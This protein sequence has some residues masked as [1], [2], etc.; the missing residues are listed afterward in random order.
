MRLARALVGARVLPAALATLAAASA[1]ARP[2][3]VEDRLGDAIATWDT[4]AA[5]ALLDAAD[6]MPRSRSLALTGY[7]QFLE[8]DYRR[9]EDALARASSGDDLARRLLPVVRA[10]REA[11]RDFAKASS[12]SG[13]F[14]IRYRA[15]PDEAALPY[16]LEAADAAWLAVTARLGPEGPSR[17]RIELLPTLEALSA[18]SGLTVPEVHESGAVAVC[19]FNKLMLVSPS[20]LPWGY[21]YADTVA[22]ELVHYV[23]TLRGG[24]DLPVWFQE[25][26]AKYLEPAWRGGKPGELTRGAR[27]RL[28]TALAQGRLVPFSAIRTSL[29]KLP[30]E[31]VAL[32]FAELSTFAGALERD[33]GPEVFARLATEMGRGD[34]DAAFR[35]VTGRTPADAASEWSK[36]LARRG[37]DA[38]EGRV[39]TVLA[40]EA[41]EDLARRL[42]PD[43]AEPVRL[44]DLLQARGRPAAAAVEYRKALS[45]SPEPH[46]A[47]VARLA[48]VLVAASSAAEAVAALDAA[49]L[50]EGEYPILSG[51]RG[52]ALV[53]LGRSG[54][55]M[56][57]LLA[58]VRTDPY[59]PAVHEALSRA[60]GDAGDATA[61]DRERRLAA[62]WR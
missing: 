48:S 45:G 25:A 47:I 39:P 4:R 49:R 7:V 61:A 62:M 15:G 36:D 23:L 29:A 30:S 1:Q 5:R 9:A 28:S 40:R 10:T 21:P 17:I 60:Y 38:P 6:D 12:R 11:I 46:P 55:A 34:P 16:L 18:A 13:R 50:D 57:H 31:S 54:E 33:H 44:G 56:P 14:V 26:V 32:A 19:K 51:I 35:R 41:E 42:P 43:V 27:D 2:A 3:A 22:H 52:R 59:D 37:F 20:A 53:A 58:A 24:E 8:G